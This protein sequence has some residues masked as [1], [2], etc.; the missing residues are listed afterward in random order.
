[1]AED[2][3]CEGSINLAFVALRT[4][5]PLLIKMESSGQI[6]F[7]TDDMELAGVLVQ[8]LIAYL[9]IIDLQVTCDFPEELEN[10]LQI[11]VKVSIHLIAPIDSVAS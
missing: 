2:L 11:L 9:N 6:T 7:R 3:A 10:L 1:M 8:S 5:K 4:N